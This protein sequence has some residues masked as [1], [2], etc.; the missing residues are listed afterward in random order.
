MPTVYTDIMRDIVRLMIPDG[1]YI[2]FNHNLYYA[3]RRQVNHILKYDP[4]ASAETISNLLKEMKSYAKAYDDM[5][6]S[7]PGVYKYTAPWFDH[8]EED[9][10]EWLGN[11]GE[12]M[13]Q[14]F[15][16]Y[17]EEAQFDSLRNHETFLSLKCTN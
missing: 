16:K 7:K 13:T 15:Y 5:V 14:D 3:V 8:I 11:E 6:F 4:N 9:T 17:L 12:P 1:N 2:E 10:R